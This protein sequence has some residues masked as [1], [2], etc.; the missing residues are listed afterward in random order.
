MAK[1]KEKFKKSA[2]KLTKEI[3]SLEKQIEDSIN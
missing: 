1:I 3:A 2:K